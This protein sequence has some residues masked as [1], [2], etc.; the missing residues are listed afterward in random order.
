[1]KNILKHKKIIFT[2]LAL[3]TIFVW[4]IFSI[5][6]MGRHTWALYTAQQTEAPSLIVAHG[7]GKEPSNDPL[8]HASKEIELILEAKN[9]KL[10]ITDETNDKVYEGTYDLTSLNLR[11][12]PRYA[13]VIDGKQGIV[14]FGTGFDP[15]L[16]L[17]LD[18]YHLMFEVQ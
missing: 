12:G 16:L 8:Y 6:F 2:V 17:S 4:I 18:G 5:P 1:M 11:T 7:A 14:T 15:M 9:G 3:I 10:S 13:V